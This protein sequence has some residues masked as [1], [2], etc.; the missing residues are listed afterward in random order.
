MKILV[1]HNR[2]QGRGGEDMVFEAEVAL[3]RDAGHAVETL[4][5][6]NDSIDSLATRVRATLRV[7]NNP[8][9]VRV[10]AAAIDRFRPDVVHIH[11]FFPLLSPAVI[12]LCREKRVAAVVT[13]HNYRTICAGGMLLRDGRICHKC[14]NGSNLWGVVHRCYRDSLVGSAA[15]A[16]MVSQHQHRGTWTRPGV[17]LIALTRFAKDTFVQ[18]GFR[19]E[20]IDVKPNFMQDPG[21]PDFSAPRDGVLYLGRLSPEKGVDALLRAA[22]KGGFPLRVAGSGPEE[23]RLR[24]MAPPNVTF[25]GQLTHQQ[26]MTELSRTRALVVPSLWYEGFPLVIVE[27]FG[28]GTPVIASALGGPG[29]VVTHQDTGLLSEP[30]NVNALATNVKRMLAGDSFAADCGRRARAEFLALY[31]PE[32]NLRAL[33]MVYRSAI[34]AYSA[35]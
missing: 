35:G 30:G 22:A 18:A 16:W 20:L 15:S 26:V 2:Y 7:A 8:D 12:D 31:T 25:L 9:G 21:A 6:S 24:A 11:N 1:A 34:E 29:E 3:L 33:E 19:A 13:L 5:V 23:S 27:A 4:I 17:R 32:P 28:R 14:V 10:M